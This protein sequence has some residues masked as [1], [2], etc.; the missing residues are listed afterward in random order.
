[1][2]V[3]VESADE[4]TVSQPPPLPGPVWDQMQ[5]NLYHADL[6]ASATSGFPV[7]E[8]VQ[9][10]ADMS[11]GNNAGEQGQQQRHPPTPPLLQQRVPSQ[12]RLSGAT[13]VPVPIPPQ[14]SQPQPTQASPQATGPMSSSVTIPPRPRPGRKPILQENAADRRRLQNRIAQRNFRDKR[15]QKLVETQVELEDKKQEYQEHINELQRQLAQVRKAK[16]AVEED[17]ARFKKRA[18]EAEQRAQQA[19]SKLHDLQSLPNQGFNALY[20]GRPGLPPGYSTA[21]LPI[22]NLSLIHI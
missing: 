19:E 9:P 7:P 13:R 10:R 6:A 17:N 12:Q 1:M 3:E 21:D 4:K 5:R 18:H 11:G 2:S 15:Q 20:G 8:G 22:L 14:H 16:D